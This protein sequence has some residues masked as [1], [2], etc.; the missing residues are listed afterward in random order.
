MKKVV[1]LLLLAISFVMMTLISWMK[2]QTTMY[3]HSS[4]PHTKYQMEDSHLIHK[5][6]D[7]RPFVP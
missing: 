2:F 5:Y 6:I 1:I 7:F 4:Q 3:F